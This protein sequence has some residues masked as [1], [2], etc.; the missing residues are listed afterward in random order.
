LRGLFNKI[1]II[2]EKIYSPLRHRDAE[3]ARSG[4]A[5]FHHL[6]LPAVS[7]SFPVLYKLSYVAK[8][9]LLPGM[10]GLL[11]MKLSLLSM[12]KWLSRRE[13]WG[14]GSDKEGLRTRL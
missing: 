9:Y 5:F 11:W 3:M 1:F 2:E 13:L 14:M 6:H 10:D 7:Q 12:K 8:I 4:S